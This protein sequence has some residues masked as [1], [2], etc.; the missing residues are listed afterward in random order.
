MTPAELPA[1]IERTTGAAAE[2]S[3]LL[4]DIDGEAPFPAI[5]PAALGGA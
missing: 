2:V 3:A 5:A 1:W 4:A